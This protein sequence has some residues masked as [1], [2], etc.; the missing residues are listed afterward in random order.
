MSIIAKAAVVFTVIL[1]LSFGLCGIA[2]FGGTHAPNWVGTLAFPGMALGAAGLL[3]SGIAAV[4][5][6]II[7]AMR[8][9]Q[10]RPPPPPPP[11]RG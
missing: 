3:L 1:L 4:V 7:N 10:R 2:V 9:D 11:L 6:A 5:L 8:G